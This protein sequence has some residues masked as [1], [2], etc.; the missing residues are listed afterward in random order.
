ML[1]EELDKGNIVVF[2][3]ESTGVNVTSD[4]I[5]Q[6]AAIKINNKGKVIESLK[7]F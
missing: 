4:E 5:I 2:D 7:S 3:V 1:I 6:I